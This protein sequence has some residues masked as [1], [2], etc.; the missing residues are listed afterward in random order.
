MA[1]TKVP[2]TKDELFRQELDAL[3]LENFRSMYRT[4]KCVTGNRHDAE[5]A[6]ENVFVRF[7]EGQPSRVFRKNP[8]AYLC[9]AAINEARNIVRS[10]RLRKWVDPDVSE[11]EIATHNGDENARQSLIAALSELDPNLVEMLRLRFE[12]EYSCKEIA[13]ELDRTG[14]GVA[15]NLHRALRK[16]G[17]LMT[18]PGGYTMKKRKKMNMD[19]ILRKYWPSASHEEVESAGERVWNRLEAELEKHDTSL[20]SLY[21]DGWSAP[22]LEQFQFQVLTAVSLLGDRGTVKSITAMVHKW[23]GREMVGHVYVTLALLAERGIITIH[24]DPAWEYG[25]E[26]QHRFEITEDGDRALRRAKIE[27]K[28]LVTDREDGLAERKCL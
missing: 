1:T 9:K 4:A 2:T 11:L 5:E 23:T 28:E 12:Q 10:N 22:P 27:G 6:I 15:V 14:F 17:K 26:P 16:L 13:E 25:E 24:S 8:K 21:G 7:F 20:R 18:T 3:C 19:Q